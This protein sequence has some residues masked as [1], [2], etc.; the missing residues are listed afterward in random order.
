M[1]RQLINKINTLLDELHRNV[2]AE[3][4]AALFPFGREVTISKLEIL[5]D[6]DIPQN[7]QNAP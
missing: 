1:D 3:L 4:N 7:E 6:T 2:T 5:T